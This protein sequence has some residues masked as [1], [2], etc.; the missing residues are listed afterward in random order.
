MITRQDKRVERMRIKLLKNVFKHKTMLIKLFELYE[1]NINMQKMIE[2]EKLIGTSNILWLE[3]LTDGEYLEKT[4]TLQTQMNWQNELETE[5]FM[6]DNYD[7]ISLFNTKFLW[8]EE[9]NIKL[10]DEFIDTQA[11]RNNEIKHHY[12]IKE[13]V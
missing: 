12:Q 5:L 8:Y 2:E 4:T 6:W 1:E 13:V 9:E 11:E 3:L 10:T 7:F